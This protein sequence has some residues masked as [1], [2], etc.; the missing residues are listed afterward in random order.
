MEFNAHTVECD[1]YEMFR[2]QHLP[3]MPQ[4]FYTEKGSVNKPGLIIMENL[5]NS[6]DTLTLSTSATVEQC[7]CLLRLIAKIQAH[8]MSDKVAWKGRFKDRAHSDV[9]Y[10]SFVTTFMPLLL[11][12]HPGNFLKLVLLIIYFFRF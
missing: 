9:F 5:A 7:W 3:G 12:E 4:A 11:K 2:D 10:D 1:A 8:T 6:N